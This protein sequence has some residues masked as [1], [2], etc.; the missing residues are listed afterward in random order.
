MNIQ[1]SRFLLANFLLAAALA[2][3]GMAVDR[4]VSNKGV[5]S[6]PGTVQAPWIAA[7]AIS[8]ALPGDTVYFRGE[9][10]ANPYL[11]E[12][13]VSGRPGLPI[14]FKNYPGE[15][16]VIDG[17]DNW[18][19]MANDGALRGLLTFTD[20]SYVTFDGFEIR[21]VATANT[22]DVAGVL[23]RGTSHHLTIKNCTVHNVETT[24]WQ[25]T[26][27]QGT[28]NGIAVLG[29]SVASSVNNIEISNCEVYAIKAGWSETVTFNGNVENFSVL[30][31]KIHDSNNIG[32]DCI[33]YEGVARGGGELDRAR[34]GT[35]RG[36]EIYNIDSL[37]NPA[38][39]GVRAAGGI[40]V[41]GG[42]NILIERNKVHHSNIGIEV[43]SEKA[44]T[45]SDNCLVTNNWLYQNHVAG[46]IL[47]GDPSISSG[48][49]KNTMVRNNSLFE[50]DNSTSRVGEIVIQ[51]NVQACSVI[52]NIIC[53]SKTNRFLGNWDGRGN[54]SNFIDYNCYYSG[55]GTA[56]VTSAQW[57]WSGFY[58]VG[59]A[60]WKAITGQDAHSTFADPKFALTS[61]TVDLHILSS[62][63][64]KDQAPST[65]L[66]PIGE[67]DIDGQPRAADK[68]CDLGA[69]EFVALK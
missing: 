1:P 46:V 13:T 26:G 69:D 44:R 16:P 61:G 9:V 7:Y 2:S 50:N 45:C 55:S 21:N 3:P 28:A 63:G 29:T 31:C 42:Q 20:R 36:N 64:A 6:G 22:S 57:M 37:S 52:Q 34:N 15:K 33:G 48:G 17:T 35:I 67:L 19:V 5:A 40:Y 11:V 4:Y 24:L 18:K 25:K 39:G 54:A 47:G 65:F 56:A 59:F 58:R 66:C 68:K 49:V 41:D 30:N 60:A 14:L 32:I 43:G 38:Y 53:A 62:S 10:F 12:I 8:H 27:P 51:I 23:I